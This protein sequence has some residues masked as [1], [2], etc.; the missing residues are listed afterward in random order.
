MNLFSDEDGA[1]CGDDATPNTSG[2]VR[3]DLSDWQER[4]ATLVLSKVK[5]FS[6]SLN[7]LLHSLYFPF[8]LSK[9][10]VVQMCVKHLSC[11]PC[12]G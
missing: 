7:L 10:L 4:H 2:N 11:F 9:F 12:L 5:V 8:M 6:V 3:E 1:N